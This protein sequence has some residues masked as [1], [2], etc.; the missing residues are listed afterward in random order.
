MTPIAVEVSNLSMMYNLSRNKEQ[1]LKEY[2]INMVKKKLQFDEFWALS[3]ISFSINKGSSLGI[4]GV[5]GSGKSTLLKLI[6]GLMKPT[7]GKIYIAGSVAPLIELGGGFDRDMS[8]EENIY[9]M[10]AMH[11]HSK[12]FMK[13]KLEE[14]IDFAE[15]NEFMGV[16]VRNFSS[17]MLSRLAFAI[18]TLVKADILIVDEVLSVGDAE[19]RVKCENRMTEMRS[20]GTTVLFVSHSVEQVKKICDKALWLDYGKM[21]M[22]GEAAAVCDAYSHPLSEGVAVQ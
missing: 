21:T 2:V 16:P 12:K 1:R 18:A 4:I 10:G 3:D 19:F 7:S 13:S 22:F 8:A 9:F 15:L 11:G 20:E 14:I 5:N 6:A 17:G